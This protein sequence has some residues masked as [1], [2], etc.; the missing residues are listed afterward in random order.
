MVTVIVITEVRIREIVTHSSVSSHMSTTNIFSVYVTH[1][2][3]NNSI[4]HRSIS[5]FFRRINCRN[6]ILTLT[7]RARE[8]HRGILA[9]GCGSGDRAQQGPYKN[10]RG[11]IFPSTARA[12]YRLISTLLYGTRVMLLCYDYF[13]ECEIGV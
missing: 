8:P 1:S 2:V 3:K 11:P 13:A 12:S 5:I 4:W 9:R 10:D 7:N 6:V